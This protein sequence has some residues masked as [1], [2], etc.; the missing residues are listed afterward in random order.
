MLTPKELLRKA[1]Q[2]LRQRPTL[3]LMVAAVQFKR[4]GCGNVSAYGKRSNDMERKAQAPA[5]GEKEAKQGR[6]A[7]SGQGIGETLRAAGISRATYYGRR[8]RGWSE[9]QAL[10]VPVNEQNR[11]GAVRKVG[12]G[13][14]LEAAGISRVTYYARLRRGWSEA[15]ALSVPVGESVGRPA[16]LVMP[17]GQAAVDVATGNG[18]HR[19]TFYRNVR[20]GKSLKDA[21]GC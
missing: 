7:V 20:R 19:R 3:R 18:V 16:R 2:R 5:C 9:D 13:E 1:M 21:A 6:K 11:A 14:K 10:S 8:R 12:I 4:K 17:D 15:A